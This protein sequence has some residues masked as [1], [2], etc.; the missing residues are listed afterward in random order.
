M[1]RIRKIASLVVFIPLGIVLII[2]C[3]AN[4]EPVRLAL[5]PFQPSDSVLSVTA[6][7]FLMLFLALL[8]GMLVGAVATWFAQAKYRRQARVEARA[9]IA[10]EKQSGSSAPRATEKA[11]AISG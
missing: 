7:L 8:V 5:N 4:R 1:S 3:V 11:V 10:R 6:P 9:A 2:L